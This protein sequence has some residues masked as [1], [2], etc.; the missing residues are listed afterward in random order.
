MNVGRHEMGPL[1]AANNPFV[2]VVP[3]LN[4]G[5]RVTLPAVPANLRSW[6]HIP[7]SKQPSIV[8]SSHFECSQSQSPRFLAGITFFIDIGD[9]FHGTHHQ[10]L[11]RSV[12]YPTSL[13]ILDGTTEMV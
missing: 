9:N 6:F 11:V 10:R 12:P 13:L 7:H 8:S 2:M 4:R 5:F 1:Q 3:S